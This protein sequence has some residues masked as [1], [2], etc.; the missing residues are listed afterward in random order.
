MVWHNQLIAISARGIG[1]EVGVS[2]DRSSLSFLKQQ[3]KFRFQIAT[4]RQQPL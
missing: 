2:F 1:N 4:V 3:L